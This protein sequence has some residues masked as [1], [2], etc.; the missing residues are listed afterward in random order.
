MAVKKNLQIKDE[1]ESAILRGL[2]DDESRAATIKPALDYLKMYPVDDAALGD[3]STLRGP[4]K[5]V[6]KEFQGEFL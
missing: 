3:Q 5:G 2:Q 4:T 1:V 6:L